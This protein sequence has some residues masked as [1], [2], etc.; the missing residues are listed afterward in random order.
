[1]ANKPDPNLLELEKKQKERMNEQKDKYIQSERNKI[2]AKR[3]EKA[4]QD[5]KK[6]KEPEVK[7][8]RPVE[9]KIER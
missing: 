4:L 7:F 2:R 9:G 5:A 8:E 6:Y 1:M 3:T